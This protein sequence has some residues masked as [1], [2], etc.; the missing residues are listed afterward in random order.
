M[1]FT[2]DLLHYFWKTG[3]LKTQQ[4]STV[5]GE[6]LQIIHAGFHNTHAGPDFENALIEIG[7]TKWAGNVE[8]HLYSSDWFKHR[9]EFDEAYQNVILHVVYEHDR[10]VFRKDGTEIPVLELK[11][12]IPFAL[13]KT[14]KHLMA[15]ASWVPCAKAL[16]RVDECHQQA[17]LNRVMMERL[18]SK[19]QEISELLTQQKGSWD[20]AFYIYLAKHFGFKTNALPFECL[21]KSLPQQILA[22][23]KN[24]S[25][26]IEAL[27]FGQ[28]GLL[29]SD[30]VDDYP[31]KLKVEYDFLRKK[32]GLKPIEPGIWKYMRLRPANFP[33]IRLAQFS[34]LVIK[35]MHLFSKIL[36]M[37]D[38]SSI[39]TLFSDLPVHPY[40]EHHYLF[41]S[42]TERHSVQIGSS[43]IQ[44][45]LI[46]VVVNFLFS[47]GKH[48]D[49]EMYC[50]RAI[51]ML[52][53]LPAENNLITRNYH[54]LGL[55]AQSAL[56]SQALISLKKNYCDQKKCLFCGIGSQILQRKI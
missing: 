49:Q 6:P 15:A 46:N 26:Q 40:W 8:M 30:F 9:H 50:S 39:R 24:K 17:F 29:G 42:Q 3:F 32:Y 28:A 56:A 11:S 12:I 4:F 52:E 21:A 27:I 25:L 45:L 2:E 36:A 14:Y 7:A 51:H 43:S 13:I 33:T 31:A 34:A 44:N 55:K 19:Q 5:S 53:H 37:D 47:Y 48:H 38:F 20:D 10:A 23:H 16:S 35:S 18:A 54:Q 1:D 41:K 22:K